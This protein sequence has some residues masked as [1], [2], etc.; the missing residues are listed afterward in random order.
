MKIVYCFLLAAAI[1]VNTAFADLVSRVQYRGKLDLEWKDAFVKNDLSG[2]ATDE[3]PDETTVHGDLWNNFQERRWQIDFK[4]SLTDSLKLEVGYDIGPETEVKIDF[5]IYPRGHPETINSVKMK[6]ETLEAHYDDTVDTFEWRGFPILQTPSQSFPGNPFYALSIFFSYDGN[7]PSH[8]AGE[9]DY[10]N[11]LFQTNVHLD[12]LGM[13]MHPSGQWL[14]GGGFNVHGTE[15]TEAE[16]K[17]FGRRIFIRNAF[18]GFEDPLSVRSYINGIVPRMDFSMDTKQEM[19]ADFT[20]SAQMEDTPGDNDVFSYDIKASYRL[21]SYDLQIGLF[22]N[23]WY[24]AT[25]NDD[26]SREFDWLG[27]FYSPDA[28]NP[29]WMYH[30]DT[31]WNKATQSS[32]YDDLYHYNL[33][34]GWLYTKQDWYPWV[35]VLNGGDDPYWAQRIEG[36]RDLWGNVGNEWIRITPQF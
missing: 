23:P 34:Y 5:F 28:L 8:P 14:W 4:H 21:N 31:G 16:M 20:L 36:S 22:S 9:F 2:F 30:M 24:G 26:T 27:K 7:S 19:P 29:E 25:E 18:G 12:D 15:D 1:V 17:V 11:T 32:T 35:Y 6:G 33:D 10:G 13:L 3:A